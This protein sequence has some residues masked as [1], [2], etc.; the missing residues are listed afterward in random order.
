MRCVQMVKY[1]IH[2]HI[3]LFAGAVVWLFDMTARQPT[4]KVY[5]LEQAQKCLSVGKI[6]MFRL[7]FSS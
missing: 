2:R 7:D 5:Q 4:V 6:L 3:K 1:T